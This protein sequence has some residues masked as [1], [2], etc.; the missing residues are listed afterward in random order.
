MEQEGVIKYQLFF[1]HEKLVIAPSILEE[2]NLCRHALSGQSLI[3][4]DDERYDGYGFGNISRRA[5][6]HRSAFLI[7]GTQTGHLRTLTGGDL[8]YAE[9]VD[10]VHNCVTARGEVEPSSEAM[11]H[12][13]LYQVSQCINAVVHVHSPDI[14][15]QADQLGLLFTAAST[16]YGTPQM[17]S[18]VKALA[19]ALLMT[20]LPFIFVMKGHEDGVVAAGPSLSSCCELIVQTLNQAK[21]VSLQT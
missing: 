4:Q 8:A 2:I 12:G 21:S 20:D 19:A 18:E 6:R 10:A 17:A 15:Q 16:P 5:D 1:S 11:T 3:G 14:W 7:S 9:S 13:V